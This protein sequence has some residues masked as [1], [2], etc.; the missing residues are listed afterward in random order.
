VLYVCPSFAIEI[1]PG[2]LT[3]LTA[4]VVASFTIE[5]AAVA[6]ALARDPRWSA[7]RLVTQTVIVGAVLFLIALAR[8]WDDLDH[9]NPLTWVLIGGSA[10]T[11]VATAV[12][13][14]DLDQRAH[15]AASVS[16][17]A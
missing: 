12:L 14:R 6:I 15:D 16:S 3:P 17:G 9:S 7:W 10:A 5:G 11:A 4:R 8:G 13:H 2:E 1:W